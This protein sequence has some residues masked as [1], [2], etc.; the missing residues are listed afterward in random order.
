MVSGRS[1]GTPR[2]SRGL[3]LVGALL[4]TAGLAAVLAFEA[5]RADRSHRRVT[6]QVLRDYVRFAARELARHTSHDIDAHAGELLDQLAC[7]SPERSAAWALGR[8]TDGECSGGAGVVPDSYIRFDPHR[9]AIVDAVGGLDASGTA[10]IARVLAEIPAGQTRGQVVLTQSGRPV[11]LYWRSFQDPSV[12]PVHAIALGEPTLGV[13]VERI[14]DEQ[15]LLPKALVEPRAQRVH[16]TAELRL[17]DGSVLHRTGADASSPFSAEESLELGGGED[18]RVVVSLSERAAGELV[19]GGL[20]RSRLPLLAT[21]L[22]IAVGL[23]GTAV[24]QLRREHELAQLR[25]A[26]VSGVSHELRTPLAQIR[27]FAETLRYRRVR[28]SDEVERSLCI[29]DEEAGRLSHLVDNLL[30]FHRDGR[31]VTSIRLEPL[32]LATF[33]A[34]TVDR[35]APLV[36]VRH[37]RFVVDIPAGLMAQA[38]ADAMTRV[39]TN[40]LDNA[41]KYGREGQTVRITSKQIANRVR[42]V[43]DDEGSGVRRSDRQRIWEPFVRAGRGD[44]AVTGT[45]IGLSVVR[46]LMAAMGGRAWAEDAPGGGARFVIELQAPPPHG[47]EDRPME[48]SHAPA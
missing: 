20:P 7:D 46:E 30:A 2:R 25:D 28:S 13:I 48:P 35:F 10:E 16:L 32:E 24:H 31:T 47:A 33:V 37:N 42:L 15:P 36:S 22:F 14:L 19:I 43:I 23:V 6:E 26:F 39:L 8:L 27:L 44:G 1:P 9:G 45:G 18:L 5:Y 12:V 41:V 3:L 34:E 11:L 38:D 4:L 17:A 29:I 21:L 40:L